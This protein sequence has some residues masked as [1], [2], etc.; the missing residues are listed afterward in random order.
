MLDAAAGGIAQSSRARSRYVEPLPRFF[1]A[2]TMQVMLKAVEYGSVSKASRKLGQPLAT[3]SHKVSELE[4]Q[5][6][7]DLLIRSLRS[8][9]D[10]RRPDLHHGDQDRPG[11]AERGRARR[12]RCR[13]AGLAGAGVIRIMSYQVA[14]HGRDD[15]LQLLI[16]A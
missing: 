7:A 4:S 10:T 6:K 1:E 3:V 2:G 14:D 13:Y 9:A 11:A 8:G 5:M 16:E 15:L 12:R